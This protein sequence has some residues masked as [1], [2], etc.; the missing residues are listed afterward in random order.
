MLL[1]SD[2]QTCENLLKQKL[3]IVG[4]GHYILSV[5]HRTFGR[6]EPDGGAKLFHMHIDQMALN[7]LNGEVFVADN[8]AHIIYT[9]N[10]SSMQSK[11]LVSRNVGNVSAMGFGKSMIL[12]MYTL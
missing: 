9:V 6:H 5:K 8:Y 7:T 2:N 12:I 3:L 1:K 10:T 11:P 4:M